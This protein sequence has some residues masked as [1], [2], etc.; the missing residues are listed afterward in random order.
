MN[1]RMNERITTPMS[2]GSLG[3]W[4]TAYGPQEQLLQFWSIL[5]LCILL[6]YLSRWA[7]VTCYA[8]VIQHEL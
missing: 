8:Y 7:K 6:V 2:I 4:S 5:H 1:E 3:T